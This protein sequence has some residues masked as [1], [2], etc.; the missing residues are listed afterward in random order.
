[1]LL[2][3]AKRLAMGIGTLVM[4][5][6]LTFLLV[7]STGSSP[8]AVKAGAEGTEEVV[9]ELNEEL[10]WNRPLPVQFVDGL[11][12]LARLDLG[13]SLINGGDVKEDLKDRVPVTTSVAVLAT[14][15]SGVLGTLIGVAAA[16]RGGFAA[17]LANL[18]AGLA[19]SIPAFWLGAILAYLLAIKFDIFPATGYTNLRDDPRGWLTSLA[20]PVITL[21]VGS[22]AIVSRQAA[23]GMRDALAR[24][25]IMTLRAVGTPEWRI[26]YIHALRLAGLP[27]VAIL[28][29]QFVVIFGTS[30]VIERLF[31]LPG[32]GQ[33][34]QAAAASS[35]FTSLTGVVVVSA[36][37]VVL[38]NL[39]LD[40]VLAALD[41][42]LRT[43]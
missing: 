3:L 22:S 18:G 13:T 8:G 12:D 10:G 24:E 17:K 30:V 15:V 1:M 43:R 9:N 26:R 19:L 41:P 4:A 21:G 29:V 28:G 38:M 27:I 42:K 40:V 36:A 35:D 6:A 5:Y 16:V 33:A 39:V 25:H 31:V 37:V 2:Y 7:H 14:L 34:G 23:V 11:G 32:L 20:L